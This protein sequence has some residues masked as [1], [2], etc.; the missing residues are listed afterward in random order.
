MCPSPEDAKQPDTDQ[1]EPE[2]VDEQVAIAKS[3]LQALREKAEESDRYLDGLLRAQAELL[4]FQKRM[5]KQLGA[6]R[7]EAIWEFASSMLPALDDLARALAAVEGSQPQANDYKAFVNGIRMIESQIY[8]TLADYSITP[9]EAMGQPFDPAFHEA[10][11][12]IPNSDYPDG[13]VIEDLRKGFAAG[14]R[15]LRASQVAV[16]MAVDAGGS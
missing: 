13:T 14:D 16:S 5:R 11:L 7:D 8:K 1:A 3:E 6:R 10:V 2:A 15:V 12:Q 9:I 4:N